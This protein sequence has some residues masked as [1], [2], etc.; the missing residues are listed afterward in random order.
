MTSNEISIE[1]ENDNDNPEEENRFLDWGSGTIHVAG[2]EIAINNNVVK[3]SDIKKLITYFKLNDQKFKKFKLMTNVLPKYLTDKKLR[4][5]IGAN[6]WKILRKDLY[7]KSQ[8]KCDICTKDTEK[9]GVRFV[10]A[11]TFEYDFDNSKIIL[12]NLN[13]ICGLCGLSRNFGTGFA[14]DDEKKKEVKEHFL[15][16]NECSIEEYEEY[17]KYI[18][19]LN[20]LLLFPEIIKW[21]LDYGEFESQIT[22]KNKKDQNK[23][24]PKSTIWR[25]NK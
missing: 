6:K 12:K 17:K 13:I 11:D 16:V 23:Q 22:I 8:H 5:V 3:E 7:D 24:K 25:K 9:E 1:N 15:K 2:L 20:I 19:D 21:E 18:L 14:I 4:N 10:L